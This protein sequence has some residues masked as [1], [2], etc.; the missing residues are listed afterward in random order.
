LRRYGRAVGWNFAISVAAG[1]T[2]ADLRSSGAVVEDGTLTVDEAT[3]SRF[4]GV[5]VLEHDAGLVFLNGDASLF[6]EAPRIAAALDRPLCTAVF[7]S[8]S[9]TWVWSI[10]GPGSDR[11]RVWSAG[12]EVEAVGTPHP[13]EAGIDTLDEDTLFDLLRRAT[14]VPMDGDFLWRSCRRVSWPRG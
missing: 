10:D 12:Q 1:A 7:H 9:D 5:A 11:R 8:V 6:E 2:A 14:G 13:A 3:S 4:T